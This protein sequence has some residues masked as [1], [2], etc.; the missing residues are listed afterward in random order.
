MGKTPTEFS[1]T[2]PPAPHLFWDFPIFRR[3]LLAGAAQGPFPGGAPGP[4]SPG[5]VTGAGRRDASQAAPG[6]RGGREAALP[7]RGGVRA[8][9]PPP[10]RRPASPSSTS[11]RGRGAGVA[12]GDPGKGT[13][14]GR[15][16][17]Q[18]LL[19]QPESESEIAGGGG[20]CLGGGRRGCGEPGAAQDRAGER[21][22]Q[23]DRP[24]PQ[25]PAA[26]VSMD[27]TSPLLSLQDNGFSMVSPNPAGTSHDEM[28]KLKEELKKWKASSIK[29]IDLWKLAE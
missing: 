24:P 16:A 11:L 3:A 9:C 13:G 23:R 26:A 14:E 20:R 2:S 10:R 21:S 6:A 15:G 5:P 12:R 7:P 29:H 22:S 8:G 28:E 1:G 25:G 18:P 27:F 4:R 17:R 19:S